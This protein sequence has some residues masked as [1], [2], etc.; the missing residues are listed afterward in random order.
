LQLEPAE[1]GG[2]VAGADEFE[3][4]AADRFEI[5][6][7]LWSRT[8]FRDEAVIGVDGQLFRGGRASGEGESENGGGGKK[9]REAG[10]P[11]LLCRGARAAGGAPWP[12]LRRHGPVQV[13]RVRKARLSRWNGSPRRGRH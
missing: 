11:C 9:M 13:L 3:I 6:L 1:K 12:F 10:H 7:D 2:A 5:R 8:P 4:A